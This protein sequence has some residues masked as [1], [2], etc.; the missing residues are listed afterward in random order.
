MIWTI[1]TAIIVYLISGYVLYM[2]YRR[3]YYNKKSW[4]Y[5]DYENKMH[6]ISVFIPLMNTLL[7]IGL[8]ILEWRHVDYRNEHRYTFFK[9]KENNNNI[10]KR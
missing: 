5:G 8:P 1:I 9:K 4:G 3:H 2:F 6:I 7:A 10:T